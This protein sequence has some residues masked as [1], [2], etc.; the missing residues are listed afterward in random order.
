MTTQAVVL[1]NKETRV[2]RGLFDSVLAAGISG[3]GHGNMSLS[4]GDHRDS[5]KNRENFLGE[6]GIDLSRLVCAKQ[7]HGRGV[8]LVEGIDAGKGAFSYEDAIEDT[9][10][11]ITDQRGLALTIFTAD[12][13]PVFLYDP[14]TNSIGLVHAGWKGTKA[15]IAADTVL[16]MGKRFNISPADLRAWMGPAIGGCCYQ[17]GPEFEGLFDSGLAKKNN[18][19][20]LDLAG[21]NKEQLLS[22][23]LQDKNISASRLCTVCNDGQ[24]FSYRREGA[25]AGRMMSVMMLR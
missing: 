1:K 13:L 17:V 23:G 5:L 12:C 22:C 15:G 21:V 16:E 19:L 20:Y 10:A 24:V 9:D 6:M 3:R 18:S 11:L 2:F 25:A 7:V 8:R 14:S 4:Y